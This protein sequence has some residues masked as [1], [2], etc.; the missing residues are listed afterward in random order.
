VEKHKRHETNLKT[1]GI[2]GDTLPELLLVAP[3]TPSTPSPSTTWWRGSSSPLDYGF[4]EVN[5]IKL[6]LVL[7]RLESHE[8]PIMIVTI[9]VSPLW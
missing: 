4:M 3:S 5:C 1:T 8:L 6:Y 2:G 9:F 7:H